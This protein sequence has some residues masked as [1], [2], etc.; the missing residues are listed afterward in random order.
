MV[1]QVNPER[2]D[3][4]ETRILDGRECLVIPLEEHVEVSG[5]VIKPKL[6]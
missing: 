6:Q 2:A 5:I 4:V 1:V 3:L